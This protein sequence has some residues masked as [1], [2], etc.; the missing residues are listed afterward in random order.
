VT[1]FTQGTD[2]IGI[3]NQGVDFNALVFGGNTIALNGITF[4]T[5]TGVD[6]TTL[7]AADFAFL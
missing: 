3:L 5:L 7:T 6:T 2:V 4:A 1:D